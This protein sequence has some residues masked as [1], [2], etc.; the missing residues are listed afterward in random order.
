MRWFCLAVALTV[1]ASAQAWTMRVPMTEAD[2]DGLSYRLT[3]EP[4]M[5]QGWSNGLR[6]TFGSHLECRRLIDRHYSTMGRN[7]PMFCL[8]QKPGPTV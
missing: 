1:P 7:R 8:V 2:A 5:P 6:F 3:D 4:V